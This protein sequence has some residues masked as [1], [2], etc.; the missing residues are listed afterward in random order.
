MTSESETF[1]ARA[2]A[3]GDDAASSELDNVRER[4]LRSQAAWE[5]MA[6]RSERVAV[7]RARNEAEK[8]AAR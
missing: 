7:Q 8:A 2:R 6:S 5:A 4:H 1:R 3:A